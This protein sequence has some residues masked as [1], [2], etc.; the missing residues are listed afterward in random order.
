MDIQQWNPIT[1]AGYNTDGVEWLFS[2]ASALD[3]TDD[4]ALKIRK[5][6]HGVVKYTGL[7]MVSEE[8]LAEVDSL[9]EYV[10]GQVKNWLN[11]LELKLKES[12]DAA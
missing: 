7:R 9:Q 6:V 10:E 12:P 8:E 11:A 3:P 4:C 5:W 1:I 2:V